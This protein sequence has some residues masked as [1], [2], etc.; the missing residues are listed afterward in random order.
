MT[1]P[2]KD[3]VGE[4]LSSLEYELNSAEYGRFNRAQIK[5][6]LL[7][8]QE[9]AEAMNDVEDLGRG[10]WMAEDAIDLIQPVLKKYR[11]E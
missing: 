6:L 4:I 3:Q 7:L 10:F 11:G 1:T 8:M 9:M 2:I 5:S